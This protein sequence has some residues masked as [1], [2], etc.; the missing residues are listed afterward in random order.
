MNNVLKY[1][2]YKKKKIFNYLMII[3]GIVIIV[4]E[5][6]ALFKVIHY[7]WG[8][9]VFIILVIVKKFNLRKQEK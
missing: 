7:I 1:K 8:L 5:I 4:L 3:L 2:E 9:L 6:L